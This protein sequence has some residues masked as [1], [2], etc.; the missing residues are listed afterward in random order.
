[1]RRSVVTSCLLAGVLALTACSGSTAGDEAAAADGPLSV[2]AAF[3][4]LQF[5]TERVAGDRAEV[6][7]L[8]A[9]G[10]EPHDLELTPQAVAALGDADLVVYEG[11]F[12]AA[13][14]DAVESEGGDNALDVSPAADLDLTYAGDVEEGEEPEPGAEVTDPHFWLDPAR[15]SAVVESVSE[16]LAETDPDGADTYAA[17][18]DALTEDLTAL[19]GEFSD[20]LAG[21][22]DRTLVTSHEAFGY[23]AERYDLEQLGISGLSP[24]EEPDAGRLAEVT[25]F[26][27]ANGVSTIYF[28]TLI[29]PAVAEAVAAETGASTAV[30]DPIEG[31]T[32]ASAGTDYLAVQRSNLE[33]LR[34]GQSC[35]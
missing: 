29:S 10:A 15:L 24:E 1:M 11:G 33:S 17:N 9:P 4:P 20:A 25:D 7:S 2:V 28:E 6:S 34:T 19:D 13:V 26:V 31:L 3:Y 21:C 5:V 18:A 22:T 27:R 8:T 32:E 16:R 14:D 30:L 12:Q 23:L 35:A